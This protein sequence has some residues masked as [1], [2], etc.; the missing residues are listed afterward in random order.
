MKKKLAAITSSI[1]LV[2]FGLAGCVSGITEPLSASEL[3][4]VAESVEKPAA[5]TK[6]SKLSASDFEESYGDLDRPDET[7]ENTSEECS[8]IAELESITRWAEGGNDYKK[9]MPST[10]RAF[11]DIDGFGWKAE[12]A[13]DADVFS[14][15]RVTVALLAFDDEESALSYAALI[16]ENVEDCFD[17]RTESNDILQALELTNFELSEENAPDFFYEYTE[18]IEISGLFDIS[19]TYDEAVGVFHFGPNLAIVAAASDEDS[20]VELGVTTSDLVDGFEELGQLIESAIEEV[21]AGPSP[22]A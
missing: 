10:L 14:Y 19:L 12:S 6:L 7:Y 3:R 5:F 13:E 9:F 16:S 2:V 22:N 17:F 11:N 8:A 15:A 1:G 4:Q 18:F 20:R 21:Q